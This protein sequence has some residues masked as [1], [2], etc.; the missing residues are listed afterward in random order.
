MDYL[1]ER[2]LKIDK[3]DKGLTKLLKKRFEIVAELMDYKHRNNLPIE[4]LKREEEIKGRY[5]GPLSREFISKL[6]DLIFSEGK[7]E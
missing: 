2:R 4:D 6:Y 7:N 5:Q 3:I 1:H